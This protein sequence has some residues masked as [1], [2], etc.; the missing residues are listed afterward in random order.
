MAKILN[1]LGISK[2]AYH[3]ENI[4]PAQKIT[5]ADSFMYGASPTTV[6]TLLGS[7]KKSAKQRQLIYQ[8]W[9]YME[10]DGICSSA[11]K[12]LVT[13]A[14]GGDKTDGKMVFIEQN[15]DYKGSDK[16]AKMVDEISADLA[17]IFNRNA[18][19]AAYTGAG[20][21]D[22]YA[23]IYSNNSGVTD[24]HYD[25][26]YRPQLVQPFEKGGRTVGYAVY[27]GEKNFERLDV[28]QLARMKM[29]RTQW[30]PQTG[31][32]EKALRA[33]ITE[34]DINN[35]PIMPSMAGGS[36][37]YNAEE[38]FDNL[39]ASL[40][41]L[42]GQRW[43]DSIDEQMVSVN[44]DGMTKDQQDRFLTSIVSMLKKSK[45]LAE[46]AVNNGRPVLERVRHLIPVF[47]DKQ[48]TQITGPSG[49]SSGRNGAITIDDVL[50][51]AKLLCGAIGVD[52]S[53][54][55][56]SDLL[57]GGLGEGGFFRTSAQAA[58]NSRS[59]RV[60]LAEFYNHIIDI[61]TM[62]RYGV[63][64]PENNRP[65][66]INF[67]GSISALE[68][69]EQ[70]TKADKMNAGILMVQAIQAFKD[71]GATK[72]MM[73]DFLTNEMM[74]SEGQAKLYAPIVEQKNEGDGGGFPG[75]SG[76]G[77]PGGFPGG[78]E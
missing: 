74:L 22:A 62:K 23:R 21:G 33:A 32:V 10:S 75:A 13:A 34:D 50:L 45:D 12:L 43:M 24:L 29:P 26:M 20:F 7:G 48:L 67:Y 44:L 47:G 17:N 36:L 66:K 54:V 49:G 16:A 76:G 52:L 35:L 71:A 40:M 8:K 31:V 11:L 69:E 18:F 9:A 6:A 39:S 63:V 68:A 19:S 5:Q 14:L 42:V 30:V 51:H 60:A 3:A 27:V 2:R 72:E 70:R 4:A 57:S 37:L 56:F 38:H 53:M 61:H 1:T 46:S 25:E 15:P 77:I 59:I 64:F 73:Q 58:E 55:G 78:E 41:G 65:W 28:S